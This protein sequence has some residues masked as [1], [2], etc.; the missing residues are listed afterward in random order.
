MTPYGVIRSASLLTTLP[1]LVK[2]LYY[3]LIR[4]RDSFRLETLPHLG[5]AHADMS[6]FALVL[7]AEVVTEADN[8]LKGHIIVFNLFFAPDPYRDFGERDGKDTHIFFSAKFIERA[9]EK[10]CVVAWKGYV[11]KQ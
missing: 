8:A 6:S 1:I 3:T 11:K 10:G 4:L 2:E 9:E 7:S 5:D